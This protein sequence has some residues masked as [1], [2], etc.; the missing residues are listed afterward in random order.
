MA[1]DLVLDRIVATV[2]ARPGLTVPELARVL[3]MLDSEL[4]EYLDELVEDDR[5][6]EESER[7]FPFGP[8]TAPKSERA[9]R[10]V[11]PEP[12]ILYQRRRPA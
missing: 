9:P 7:L 8:R 1:P 5:L 12:V 10:P 11:K 2:A 6:T 3:S 4:D